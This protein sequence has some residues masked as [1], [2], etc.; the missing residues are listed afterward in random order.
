MRHFLVEDELFGSRLHNF[1]DLQFYLATRLL[2]ELTQD[3][4]A[5]INEFMD[6]YYGEAAPSMKTFLAY[7]ERRQ[8]DQ[9]GMLASV[10]PS[11]RRYFDA[12]FF[13]ETDAMLG[14]AEKRVADDPK[15][16]A[17]VRQE[18]LAI[19]ETMLHLWNKLNKERPLPFKRE[20]VLDRLQQNYE[21]A[22]RKY[23]GWGAAAK[24]ADEARIE[25]LRNM[26]PIPPQFEGKKI[27][28]LCG[29]QLS[30]GQAG[31]NIVRTAVPDPDAAGGQAW[32]LDS[33]LAG[34]PGQHDKPPEFG[35]YDE[36]QQPKM[37]IKQVIARQDVP[38]DGK[39]HFYLVGRIK[40]TSNMYFWAHHS[41]RLAQRLHMAY[42]SSLPEQK[43][44]DV[45]ASM[46]FEGPGY[47]PGS[48]KTNSFATL[49]SSASLRSTC[50]IDR[51]ILVEVEQTAPV[52][53]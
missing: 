11:V 51:L 46:K 42:D 14:E 18:R 27:M 39:Y 4:N 30:L 16:L 5:V 10:P 47:V 41:W 40:A 38:K 24:K 53:K 43:T 31:G 29:P 50:S 6:L 49:R 35:L 36:H 22:Y 21:A 17:N 48:A 25:Y 45:Y 52:Q 3:E 8:E 28:D 23:G 7:L 20:E 1:V 2:Q 37:L 19:D 15:K 12:A 9:P 32:R 44:Y 34:P 26:P 33:S 13:V